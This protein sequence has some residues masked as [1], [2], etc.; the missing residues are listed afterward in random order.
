MSEQIVLARHDQVCDLCHHKI[1]AGERCRIV[2]DDFWPGC[3][4]EHLRCPSDSAAAILSSPLPKL[5][6][7]AP[8]N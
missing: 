3:Y 6:Q 8:A 5:P 2:R 4:F 7:M 1:R